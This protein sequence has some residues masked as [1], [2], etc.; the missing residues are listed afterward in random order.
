MQGMHH[1]HE[2]MKGFFGPY[3]MNREASGT[4]WL[5]DTTPHEGIHQT[6]ADWMLMEH[7][8]VNGVYDNQ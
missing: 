5:P 3:P 2:G 6:Y 8:L 4:S 7:A 1:D